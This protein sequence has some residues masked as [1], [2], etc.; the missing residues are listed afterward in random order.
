MWNVTL[1]SSCRVEDA[2]GCQLEVMLQPEADPTAASPAQGAA[3]SGLHA[4]QRGAADTFPNASPPQDAESTGGAPASSGS[5]ARAGVGGPVEGGD[6]GESSPQTQTY[7][8]PLCWTCPVAVRGD[9]GREVHV[10]DPGR[11]LN[12]PANLRW[13]PQSSPLSRCVA[14][15]GNVLPAERKNLPCSAPH[16]YLWVVQSSAQL[17]CDR[18]MRLGQ[19]VACQEAGKCGC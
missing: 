3:T 10:R 12:L 15:V 14:M 17:L 18:Q 13:F 2:A 1:C 19:L 11:L 6:I 8:L 5:A 4:G 16:T 7:V 9:G